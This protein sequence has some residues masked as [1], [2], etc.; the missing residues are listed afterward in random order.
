MTALR[1]KYLQ[2]QGLLGVHKVLLADH[3]YKKAIPA[4]N[5]IMANF[6]KQDA[7][8]KSFV[9]EEQAVKDFRANK[10]FGALVSSL[11]PLRDENYKQYGRRGA[12]DKAI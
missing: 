8:E 10:D 1:R 9:D 4:H 12:L 2:E 7:I 5:K 11:A 6:Q 3:F